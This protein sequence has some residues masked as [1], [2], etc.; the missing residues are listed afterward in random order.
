MQ[1]ASNERSRTARRA[2]TFSD[3]MADSR[4]SRLP[5]LVF[6][7]ATVFVGV[8][9]W[10]GTV[11]PY[12][13]LHDEFYYWAGAKN[14]AFGY[15]DHPPFAPWILAL[16]TGLLGDG[17]FPFALVPA[18]CGA[19]TI[20]VTAQMA[21]RLGADRFGQVLAALCVAAAPFYLII[22]SFFS[23][24][25][26][27]VLLWSLLCLT[28]IHLVQSDD[29][30]IWLVIGAITGVGLLNKHTFVLI[31]GAFALA[32]LLSPRRAHLRTRWPW[33]GA[34]LAIGL[35]SPNLIWNFLNGWPSL[36]FYLSRSTVN[37]PTNMLE[38]LGIQIFGTNPGTLLVT[39]SGLVGLLAS[40]R[41]RRYRPL[42]IA[43][44]I[45]IGFIVMSGLR[46]GDRI[47]GIYPLLFA[48]GATILGQQKGRITRAGRLT[49]TVS[50]LLLAIPV[51]RLSLPIRPPEKIAAFFRSIG[52]SPD[53][54]SEEN[55]ALPLYLSAR[56]EWERFADQ[57]LRAA[58]AIPVTERDRVAI[59]SPHWLYASIIEYYGRNRDIPPVIS[60]HNAYYFRRNDAD[61]R[62]IVMSVGIDPLLLERYFAHTEVLDIFECEYCVSW[63]PD[64]PMTLSRKPKQPMT[65]YLEEWQH[66][67]L[68]ASPALVHS[69]QGQ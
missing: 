53:I 15:V 23:V 19:A 32:L 41:M 47:A 16:A 28:A 33:I 39:V 31:A 22:F 6:L 46:R 49:V 11:P 18:L 50:I 13:R 59:L 30:R 8:Q 10:A 1:P 37:V 56:L 36:H 42:G 12:G 4:T 3:K 21:H 43:A 48:A 61:G 65:Q 52:Q 69:N 68:T 7:I 29:G 17:E 25:S 44:A 57:V 63:R 58:D 66:F 51:G 67:G 26:F 20:V 62:D 27:E 55:A 38:A 60:P 40:K 64:I 5:L 2:S 9:L 54:E 34:T 45:L 24:N 35:A 14:L